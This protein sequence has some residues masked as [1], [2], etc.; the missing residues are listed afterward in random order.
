M[1]AD[2]DAADDDAAGDDEPSITRGKQR[3]SE[4]VQSSDTI[5]RVPCQTMSK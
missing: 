4:Q 3:N 5:W 2:D 1:P